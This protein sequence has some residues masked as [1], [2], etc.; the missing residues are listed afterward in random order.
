M[1]VTLIP[2]TFNSAANIKTCLES[3]VSQNY[4]LFEHLII[5]GKSSDDTLNIIKG[6]QKKHP[7]IK[8]ISYKDFGIE[9]RSTQRFLK[10]KKHAALILKRLKF[11]LKNVYEINL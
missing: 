5:D 11:T 6:Y 3:L 1:K 7:Y 10:L 8:L 4:G 9:F 2:A